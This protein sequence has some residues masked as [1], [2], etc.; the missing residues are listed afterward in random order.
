MFKKIYIGSD[1][2]GFSLKELII[3]QLKNASVVVDKGAFTTASC[4]YPVFA[5]AVS[6]AVL[7]DPGSC[8]ILIC[9]TGIG[10]SM[11]ANR[12]KGIRAAVCTDAYTTR[13]TRAH[14]DAN[15]LCLGER[16]TGPGV[17]A[18]IV[19]LFLVTEF[20]G[21]RHLKRINLFEE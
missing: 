14:N 18:E 1:H 5:Q 7:A 6:Q 11:A 8:G 15:V 3:A 20:E 21:D 2:G 10:M 9:G 16:V 17:A 13:M 4:D 12:I 19:D